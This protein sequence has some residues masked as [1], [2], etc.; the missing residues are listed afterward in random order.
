[1]TT[2]RMYELA[3]SEAHKGYDWTCPKT[4]EL[5]QFSPKPAKKGRLSFSASTL[6]SW[7][8][9]GKFPKPLIINGVS[10]WT[11][12]MIESWLHSQIAAN[13]GGEI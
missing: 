7:L 8:R 5:R 10:V 12:D 4:G 2:Y 9:A 13:D 1:M 6:Y 3:S 11:E